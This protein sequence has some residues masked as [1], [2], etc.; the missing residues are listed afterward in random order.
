V[1]GFAAYIARHRVCGKPYAACVD[2]AEYLTE[3]AKNVARWKR[4]G[5]ADIER[6]VIPDG[7]TIEVMCRCFLDAHKAKRA[8]KNQSEMAL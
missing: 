3:T 5:D 1:S 4:N 6:V 7:E 8:A 2:E